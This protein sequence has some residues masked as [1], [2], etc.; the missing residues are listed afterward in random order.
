ML[1]YWILMLGHY[2][3]FATLDIDVGTL[4]IDVGT[5]DIDVGHWT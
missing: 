1:Q 2:I 5:L 3:D 4:D